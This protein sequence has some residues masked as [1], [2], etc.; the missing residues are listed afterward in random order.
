MVTEHLYTYIRKL[1]GMTVLFYCTCGRCR[2]GQVGH[3]PPKILVGWATIHFVPTRNWLVCSLILR[4]IMCHISR[5]KFTWLTCTK[6][7]FRWGSAPDTAGAVL[8]A[9]FKGPT[10]K[11]REKRGRG[12]ER[13]GKGREWGEEV[14]RG[15]G[16]PKDLGVAPPYGLVDDLQRFVNATSTMNISHH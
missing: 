8:L 5:L 15:F 6:F 10:S 9:G 2:V 7:V 11:G 14:G 1:R 12:R 13:K 16:P 4:K 3:G